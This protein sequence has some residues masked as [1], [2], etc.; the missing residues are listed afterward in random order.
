[1]LAHPV[2][3]QVGTALGESPQ[4]QERAEGSILNHFSLQLMLVQQTA[5]PTVQQPCRWRRSTMGPRAQWLAR[6]HAA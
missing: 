2:A 5:R 4:T 3:L 6:D 1:M